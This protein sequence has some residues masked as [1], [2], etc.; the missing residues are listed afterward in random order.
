MELPLGWERD[1][2]HYDCLVDDLL[3]RTVICPTRMGR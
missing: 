1:M 3:V 2:A